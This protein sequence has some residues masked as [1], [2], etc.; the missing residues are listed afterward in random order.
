VVD[1]TVVAVARAVVVV[2]R[3]VVEGGLATDDVGGMVVVVGAVVVL[4]VVATIVV[5]ATGVVGF[6]GVPFAPE[7]QP[8]STTTNRTTAERCPPDRPLLPKS[9]TIVS[10][11]QNVPW[12]LHQATTQ[13][14]T[15]PPGPLLHR[16]T[17][18][19]DDARA[20]ESWSA[21]VL[22]RAVGVDRAPLPLQVI[23]LA[24]A[25]PTLDGRTAT[26]RSS[27]WRAYPAAGPLRTRSRD[28]M[29]SVTPRLLAI[30]ESRVL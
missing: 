17:L 18:I 26:S 27:P 14:A 19:L 6:V 20:T 11:R 24:C 12:C 30:N 4:S 21:N 10:H 28:A 8:A 7:P 2:A 29:R 22:S 25:D 3:T 16:R 15:P 13:R 5:R 1:R 23:P 9:P